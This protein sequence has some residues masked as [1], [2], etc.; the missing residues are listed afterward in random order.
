MTDVG[1]D[2]IAFEAISRLKAEGMSDVEIDDTHVLPA[3]CMEIIFYDQTREMPAFPVIGPN[4]EKEWKSRP[5]KPKPEF[6]GREGNDVTE[7]FCS[8]LECGFGCRRH[9]TLSPPSSQRV[10]N[11]QLGTLQMKSHRY[12]DLLPL[13]RTQNW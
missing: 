8:R 7:L 4:G 2:I 1:D 9:G 11:S 12:V 5:L 3:H 6:H 13:P 10:T